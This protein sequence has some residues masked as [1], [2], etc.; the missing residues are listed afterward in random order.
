LVGEGSHVA[1]EGLF[2][3]G[4]QSVLERNL[5]ALIGLGLDLNMRHPQTGAPPIHY[6]GVQ[7][8]PLLARHG[9][10]VNAVDAQG[11]TLLDRVLRQSLVRRSTIAMPVHTHHTHTHRERER[12]LVTHVSVSCACVCVCGAWCACAFVCGASCVRVRSCVVSQRNTLSQSQIQATLQ[13]LGV[14][15]WD[16]HEPA[17]LWV[18][19]ADDRRKW[20]QV[21]GALASL[22][23]R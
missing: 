14:D 17:A 3:H 12:E 5:K 10:D 19:G 4:P 6:L 13:R 2:R 7:F 1:L 11:L 21:A 22:F 9:A 23:H 16:E 18:A 20:H 8:A 15:R